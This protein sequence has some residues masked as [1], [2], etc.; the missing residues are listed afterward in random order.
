[1]AGGSTIDLN[2]CLCGTPSFR[3]QLIE[4]EALI[5]D[6]EERVQKTV[7]QCKQFADAG[8]AFVDSGRLV[9]ENLF[10]LATEVT[11]N[12]TVKECLADLQATLNDIHAAQS[13]MVQ[14]VQNLVSNGLK[15]FVQSE[16][17]PLRNA[18]KAYQRSSAE[19]DKAY[20]K[21]CSMSRHNVAGAEAAQRTLETCRSS[22][23]EASLD[24]SISLNHMK[25]KKCIGVAERVLDLANCYSSFIATCS[26]S[27]SRIKEQRQ[28]L[29]TEVA[30]LT[31]AASAERKMMDDLRQSLEQA[32][33]SAVFNSAKDADYVPADA[34]VMQGYLLKRSK[35]ALKL[36]TN[37]FFFIKNNQLAYSHRKGGELTIV[38]EDLRLCTVRPVPDSDRR[39][40]FDIVTPSR[41]CTLQAESQEFY[42]AW[43]DAIRVG[44]T[45]A[46]KLDDSSTTE[47]ESGDGRGR[48][49]PQAMASQWQGLWN[50]PGNDCCVDCSAPD[51][52]WASIN[53]GITLCIDCSGI[54]RSLGVQ[55][56]K[57]RSLT[58]DDLE[59]ESVNLMQSL[60]NTLVN[61]LYL[62]T[63]P[64]EW[65]PITQHAT[66]EERKRWIIAKYVKKRFAHSPQAGGKSSRRY[67]MPIIRSHK[68]NRKNS[69]LIQSRSGAS[70]A[71]VAS[72]AGAVAV[73]NAV[74]GPAGGSGS[75]GC[76]ESPLADEKTSPVRMPDTDSKSP[77][78]SSGLAADAALC[79]TTTTTT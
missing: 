56:S 69:P 73:G 68:K 77:D 16:V 58:L 29:S 21:S 50:I 23:T 15:T 5:G 25:W 79:T 31:T 65:T 45:R 75:G 61:S 74:P 62:V 6:L 26:D 19:C 71:S 76:G 47:G 40:V 44:I 28:C 9:V 35:S 41:S 38:A 24:Y 33:R 30:S 2:E 51:P 10:S 7:R 13:T 36:W 72:G 67:S 54:H 14:S 11:A 48:R 37:R 27:T 57:V 34:V 32:N 39:F 52:T 12:P 70:G 8:H 22:L 17:K 78:G 55:T 4:H 66:K 59:P 60:G 1:M 43:M 42:D 20:T 46:F 53:L 18:C 3:N 49:S 64:N 63:I